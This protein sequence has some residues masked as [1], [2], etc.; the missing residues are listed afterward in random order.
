ME[1]WRF[2]PPHPL[3]WLECLQVLADAYMKAAADFLLSPG[4][5]EAGTEN[6]NVVEIYPLAKDEDGQQG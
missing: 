4:D 3:M 5:F 2:V 6:G 1:K